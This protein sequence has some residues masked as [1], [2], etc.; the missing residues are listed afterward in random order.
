MGAFVAVETSNS[1]GTACGWLV[2]DISQMLI[3]AK[4]PRFILNTSLLQL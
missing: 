3:S 2:Q 1:A 4:T